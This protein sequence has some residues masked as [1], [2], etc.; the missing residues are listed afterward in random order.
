MHTKKWLSVLWVLL[1]VVSPVIWA[2]QEKTGK[3]TEPKAD[4]KRDLLNLEEILKRVENRYAVSGFSASFFQESTLKAMKITD[5]ASGMLTVKPP[6]KMRWE[7]LE[8]EPQIIIS[9]GVDLW[10]HRPEDN[11]VMVGKSPVF[12][13]SGKGASFLSDIRLIRKEFK[14]N[15]SKVPQKNFYGL[16]LLPLKK[17]MDLSKIVLSISKE[18]FDVVQIITLNHYGDE[19]RINLRNYKFNLKLDDKAFKFEVP[20]G[21]DVVRMEP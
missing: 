10:M 11:Q 21:A 20:E 8:P 13:G 5:T 14:V 19:T 3:K 12:F 2:Q 6:N 18:T 7:Y 1:V 17:S 16:E 4:V 15:Q 9:N